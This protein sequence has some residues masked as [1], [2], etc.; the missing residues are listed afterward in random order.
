M[1]SGHT[2]V[3]VY[4]VA[5]RARRLLLARAAPG[6]VDAGVWTLPGGLVPFGEHPG[7]ALVRELYAQTRVQATT[8]KAVASDSRFLPLRPDGRSEDVYLVRIYYAVHAAGEPNITGASFDAAGWLPID[9]LP[10][11]SEMVPRA[12]Q[13]VGLD[14]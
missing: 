4:A 2:R 12:L 13:V 9:D 5:V 8:V 6:H 3:G 14:V 7:N 1:T 10:P 11:V